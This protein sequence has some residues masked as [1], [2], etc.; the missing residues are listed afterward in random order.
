MFRN[1]TVKALSRTLV[2]GGMYIAIFALPFALVA[3]R[4]VHSACAML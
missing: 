1:E 4:S 2:E 3:L